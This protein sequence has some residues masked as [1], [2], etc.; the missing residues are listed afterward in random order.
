M[1]QIIRSLNLIFWGVLIIIIDFTY[2]R[3]G[4]EIDLINDLIGSIMI[5]IAVFRI[6]KF[7]ISD[8][9]FKSKMNF[10]LIV[11]VI[12]ILYSISD[13][14][15]YQIPEFIIS[16][17]NLIG[18]VATWGCIMFCASMIIFSEEALLR[19]SQK[20][21]SITKKMFLWLNFIPFVVLYLIEIIFSFTK[22]I[23]LFGLAQGGIVLIL[24]IIAL[25]PVLYGLFTIHEM[26]NEIRTMNH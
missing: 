18:L 14:V 1:H 8:S 19:V 22:N 12:Q 26:K 5:F 24:L 7:Q 11:S 4:I 23:S 25:I 9:T 10:V 15:T 13:F 2:S 20:R 17:E 6:S 3:S 21:W 16:I